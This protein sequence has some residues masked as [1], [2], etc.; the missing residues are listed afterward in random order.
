L[1]RAARTSAGIYKVNQGDLRSTVLPLPCI[2]EQKEIVSEV[3]RLLSVVDNTGQTAER[4]HTR[5]ERLRQSIL[6]QA[7]SGRLVPHEGG[8]ASASAPSGNGTQ[9]PGA[10]IELGL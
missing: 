1:E 9:R 7:F 10:Q 4:E 2:A 3:E 5:A 6:K 8:T